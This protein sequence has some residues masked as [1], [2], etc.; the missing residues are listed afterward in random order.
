M[1]Q[2]RS[3]NRSGAISYRLLINQEDDVL[4]VKLSGQWAYR[5]SKA[6]WAMVVRKSQARGLNKVL[7]MFQLVDSISIQQAC[8]LARSA[9]IAFRDQNIR[10]AVADCNKRSFP[11]ISFW[12]MAADGSNSSQ[13]FEQMN[14]AEQW[15]ENN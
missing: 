11:N 15:L 2:N 1:H 3:I 7:V 13:L 8:E 5:D 4:R 14:D 9:S 6:F 10:L 12:Q